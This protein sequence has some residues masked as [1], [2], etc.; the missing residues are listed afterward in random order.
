MITK[1]AREQSL[2]QIKQKKLQNERKMF[3]IK[4]AP[5]WT[6]SRD[7]KIAAFYGLARTNW[8]AALPEEEV[9]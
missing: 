2:F 9:M 4:I 3:T 8:G 1:N 7:F 6:E 5:N